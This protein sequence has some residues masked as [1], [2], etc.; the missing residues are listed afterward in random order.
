MWVRN[1]RYSRY[2]NG[3]MNFIKALYPYMKL[4]P[5]NFKIRTNIRKSGS[6][7]VLRESLNHTAVSVRWSVSVWP[8]AALQSSSTCSASRT[9]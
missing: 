4:S 2:G 3:G 5:I 6:T 1:D 8:G 7:W 9:R